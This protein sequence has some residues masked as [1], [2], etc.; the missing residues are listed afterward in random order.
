[1]F[2]PKL[3]VTIGLLITTLGLLLWIGG[4]WLRLGRLPGD[5][6]IERDGFAFYFP[7][8][9]MLLLSAVATVILWLVN[10]VGR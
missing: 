5:V 1:M 7:I 2:V 9:T 6:A 4:K 10:R 3:L 8:T